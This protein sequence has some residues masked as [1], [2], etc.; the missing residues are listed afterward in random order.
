VVLECPAYSALWDSHG[1]LFAYLP[2]V[3]QL[4]AV[5]FSC[6]LPAFSGPL[7]ACVSLC[8]VGL[9]FQPSSPLPLGPAD[10]SLELNLPRGVALLHV[11]FRM[12]AQGSAK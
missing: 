8:A 11:L 3:S 6:P 12:R 9:L 5:I 10:L 4:A 1:P 7:P 2:L